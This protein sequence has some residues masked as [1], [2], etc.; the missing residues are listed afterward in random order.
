ML[1]DK[2]K[3]IL[4]LLILLS[5]CKKE[6]LNEIPGFIKIDD[7]ILNE[8]T[9][10]NITD[11]WVYINDQLQGIYELPAHF[12]VLEIGKNKLRIRGG[13]KNNGISSSR[14]AY[15]F[16][17]SYIEEE[18]D[19]IEAQETTIYP[20]ISYLDNTE[21]LDENS[22]IILEKTN[23]SDTS[24]V[25]SN[26]ENCNAGF[27]TDSLLTFEI[28]TQELENIPQDG[29]PV[30]LELDYKCNSQ[31]LVGTYINYIPTVIKKDLLWINPK[32]NWNKIYINLTPV[33]N[34]G[35][36]APS[37]SIFLGMQRNFNL[38]KNELY[39]KNFRVIY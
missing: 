14:A 15:S 18:L 12:P 22:D 25:F 2:I 1:I 39:F 36:D 26:E 38:T 31:F 16:Y 3:Y 33:I 9:T 8:N 5:S 4:F 30:Y 10:D 37:F 20:T 17:T 21:I 28:S 7:I 35:V 34:E 23:F 11:A 19:I 32:E 24:I 27:L 6:P 29:S 13:I